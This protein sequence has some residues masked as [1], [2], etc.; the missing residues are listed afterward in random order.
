MS[1]GSAIFEKPG[2]DRLKR[3][4]EEEIQEYFDVEC[5]DG[6]SSPEAF[7]NLKNIGVNRHVTIEGHRSA[8]ESG[9]KKRQLSGSSEKQKRRTEIPGSEKK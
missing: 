7:I 4:A 8:L 5:D 1:K 6:R 2:K 9:T 3:I